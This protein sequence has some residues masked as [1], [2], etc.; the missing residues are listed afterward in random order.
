MTQGWSS[1][2]HSKGAESVLGLHHFHL[3]LSHLSLSCLI[4]LGQ[5]RAVTQD[6]IPVMMMMSDSSIFSSLFG[7]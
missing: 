5:S 3:L 2:N 1:K 6:S 4:F 7:T